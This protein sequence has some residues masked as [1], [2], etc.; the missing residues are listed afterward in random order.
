MTGDNWSDIA[1]TLF[2]ETGQG[3][4][5]AIF[6]VS[7]QL[8]VALVLVNVVIAVLL[9][10][11]SKA[12]EHTQDD[13]MTEQ[14][15]KCVFV[16]LAENFLNYE[17]LEDLE[18]KIYMQ[19]LE[20]GGKGVP[21]LDG[22]DLWEHVDMTDTLD[23]SS[24]RTGIKKLDFI[25]PLLITQVDWDVHVVHRKLCSDDQKL[26]FMGF[27]S[28]IKYS[29][30]KCQL[31][32]LNLAQ[33]FESDTWAR[34]QQKALFLG[35]RDWPCFTAYSSIFL[36]NLRGTSTHHLTL[37]LC[38]A[39]SRNLHSQCIRKSW[40]LNSTRPFIFPR[41]ALPRSLLSIHSL[42][43]CFT[44]QIKAIL[45]ED[46][47]YMRKAEDAHRYLGL[48][49]NGMDKHYEQ[50]LAGNELMKRMVKDIRKANSRLGRM[51]KEVGASPNGVRLQGQLV[52][53][54]ASSQ[55]VRLT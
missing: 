35:V 8:I 17:T 34:E 42:I 30:R 22:Q 11:F 26:G 12:A 51:V 37:I 33:E 52:E 24:F 27:M 14:G 50:Q 44:V 48:S 55:I 49:W 40:V 15:P 41:D 18:C 13:S 39:T 28:L 25:P 4:G 45:L 5:V 16:R 6:F 46:Q 20:V 54:K 21:L 9:D 38:L 32:S 36:V 19:F 3:P 53:T 31:W 29:L 10:E 23:F 43:H 47:E 1:R 7:F 2:V